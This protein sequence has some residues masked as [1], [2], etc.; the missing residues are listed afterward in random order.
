[1]QGASAPAPGRPL[2]CGLSVRVAADNVAAAAGAPTVDVPRFLLAQSAG[3]VARHV[4]CGRCD[5]PLGLRFAGAD[6][7]LFSVA[8]DAA[9]TVVRA[10]S[11]VEMMRE[12]NFTLRFGQTCGASSTAARR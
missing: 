4:A 12:G 11:D 10:A 2:E 6:A 1:M 3:R 9:A 5:A 8:G 7:A